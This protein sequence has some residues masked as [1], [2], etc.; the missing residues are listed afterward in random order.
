M[1]MVD[2]SL[3]TF[4]LTTQ[5]VLGYET[6][7]CAAG[8]C[9]YSFEWVYQKWILYQISFLLNINVPYF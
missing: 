5:K 7:Y 9:A 4:C 8:A 6:F 2:L 3:F 1:K